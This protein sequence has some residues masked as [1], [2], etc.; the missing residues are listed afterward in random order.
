MFSITLHACNS[1][2]EIEQNLTKELHN[3]KQGTMTTL[4]SLPEEILHKIVKDAALRGD[5]GYWSCCDL[6]KNKYDSRP[7]K[8]DH[9]F[10][11]DVVSK[12]SVRFEKIS[13]DETFWEDEG[14]VFKLLCISSNKGP[15]LFDVQAK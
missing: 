7:C 10:L 15:Y 12:I 2:I 1:T 9:D 5:V 3:I 6:Y 8:F 11:V 4:S 13:R 14:S